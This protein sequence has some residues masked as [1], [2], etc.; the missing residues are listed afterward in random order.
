[1]RVGGAKDLMESGASIPLIMSRGRWS[2][3]D[4]VTRYIE[5]NS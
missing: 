3:I 4:T 1:M 2:K 5:S